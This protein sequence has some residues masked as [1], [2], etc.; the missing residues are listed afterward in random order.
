[1]A[2][3]LLSGESKWAT[4]HSTVRPTYAEGANVGSVSV[5]LHR[6]LHGAGEIVIVP[7]AE[8]PTQ[9]VQR[10]RRRVTDAGRCNAGNGVP[11]L[12]RI[13]LKEREPLTYQ[14]AIFLFE[15]DS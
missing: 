13:A 12:R 1:M 15:F 2:S 6:R 3:T 4:Q 14:R 11:R 9:A 10:D 5:T 8:P 7:I